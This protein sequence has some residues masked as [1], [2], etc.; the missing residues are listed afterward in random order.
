LD[1]SVEFALNE[2]DG[3]FR[4]SYRSVRFPFVFLRFVARVIIASCSF[5]DG[6]LSGCLLASHR[7][8]GV[9]IEFTFAMKKLKQHGGG[10]RFALFGVEMRQVLLAP[11]STFC[12]KIFHFH[13]LWHYYQRSQNLLGRFLT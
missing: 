11:F 8:L 1:G 5:S 2:R 3:N 12:L 13:S 9:G 4:R 7:S 6:K 10:S